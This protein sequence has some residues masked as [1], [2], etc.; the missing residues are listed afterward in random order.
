MEKKP[1]DIGF[2][3]SATGRVAIVRGHRLAVWEV[4]DVHEQIKSITRT[5]HHLRWSV[6]LVRSVL[7]YAAANRPEIEQQ[8]SAEF[9]Q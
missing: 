8:R 4:V 2:R 7:E 5:A 1:T 9:A 3:D 6:A